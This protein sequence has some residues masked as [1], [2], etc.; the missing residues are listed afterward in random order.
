MCIV[1][2]NK[3][4]NRLKRREANKHS[5]GEGGWLKK[6]NTP[7]GLGRASSSSLSRLIDTYDNIITGAHPGTTGRQQTTTLFCL[8]SVVSS[9]QITRPI[10]EEN[11]RDHGILATYSVGGGC[12][13]VGWGGLGERGLA[14]NVS[15]AS[16]A[17][18]PDINL[19]QQGP[20]S[21]LAKFTIPLLLAHTHTHTKY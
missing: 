5:N 15:C 19:T 18:M 10:V 17:E 2:P 3:R 12:G 21:V 20:C 1:F 11:D 9:H 8:D 16:I 7:K 13:G 6:R 14:E 4:V